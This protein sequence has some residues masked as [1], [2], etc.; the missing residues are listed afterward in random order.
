MCMAAAVA[1]TMRRMRSTG[2]DFHR[3]HG[4]T[5]TLA[6][7]VTASPEH[8]LASVARLADL[9]EQG[10]IAGIHLEGPWLSELRPGAHQV[11]ELRDPDR[12][13]LAAVLAAGRGAIRMITFAPERPGALE[14]IRMAVDDGVVAA[15]GHT[16]ASYASARAGIAA[17]A[18]VA[19]HLFNAMA[20]IHHREPGP[21]VALLEDPRVVVEVV[22]DGVH[23]HPVIYGHVVAAAGPNRVALVTD[24]IA[25]AGLAD[26]DYVLGQLTVRGDRRIAE[27]CRSGHD[28]RQH[29]DHRSTLSE[30][31]PIQRLWPGR[32][33]CS[34]PRVRPR[35][36]R[37]A[38]SG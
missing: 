2:I 30:C 17:G 34:P 36:T 12:D 32:T 16:D 22:L 10:V 28:R 8:L 11:S 25:A 14:A 5:T 18:T 13:E 33:P 35:S 6:S 23:L 24:A 1:L 3:E 15:I 21:I 4:T 31:R 26:G 27:A 20:P 9:T 7:V 29:R 19:T 38:C 37:P